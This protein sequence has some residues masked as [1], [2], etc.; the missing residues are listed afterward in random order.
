[1]PVR[2]AS[3][4]DVVKVALYWRATEDVNR[5][6]VVSLL[7]NDANQEPKVE[8]QGRPVDDTYPTTEWDKGEV[9]RDWHDLRLPADTPPGNYELLLQVLEEGKTIGQT[10]LGR[11]E[12]RGRPHHFEVP[13]I[14]QPLEARL[15][16]TLLLLG[17]D[18]SS[19]D[20]KPGEALHLTLYWQALQEMGVSYTVF[21]HLL[22]ASERTWGQM[23]S[24]PQLGEAPTTSWVPGEVIADAYDIFVDAGAPPG[25]YV[26]EIGM[27]DATTG[28][29][30]LVS[31]DGQLLEGDRLVLGRIQVLP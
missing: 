24:I 10:S 3:P 9:L 29:R 22:D 14:Q 19:E 31:I 12:V 5:D 15:G 4:G 25:D 27:Y 26:I 23:D 30:L 16:D 28:R 2:T 17:Y 6:Y 7:L 1:V 18:L 20:V 21:T 8:Q 11:V 13:G